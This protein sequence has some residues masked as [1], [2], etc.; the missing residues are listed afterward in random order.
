MFRPSNR[1]LHQLMTRTEHQLLSHMRTMRL[2]HFNTDIQQFVF[3]WM[4]WLAR[5][6]SNSLSVSR[7]M[8]KGHFDCW[9]SGSNDPVAAGHAWT[10]VNLPFKDSSHRMTRV[11]GGDDFIK[12]SLM[13]VNTRSHSISP[14]AWNTPTR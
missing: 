6:I 13:E 12:N 2:R 3:P 8:G 10:E 14:H 7:S 1:E 4:F 9:G 5:V 11:S